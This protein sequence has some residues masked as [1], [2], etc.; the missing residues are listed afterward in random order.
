MPSFWR[1]LKISITLREETNVVQLKIR[2]QGKGFAPSV[3]SEG[4]GLLSMR[5]RMR[6][7]GGAL[8]ITSQSGS[9]TEITAEI[10]RESDWEIGKA[11]GKNA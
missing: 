3:P 4:I 5:E 10:P 8:T 2:D 6:I 11:K 1:A 9:G 7:V